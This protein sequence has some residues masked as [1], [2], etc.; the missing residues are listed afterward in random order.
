M[1]ID[2]YLGRQSSLV[3]QRSTN[4]KL[5]LAMSAVSDLDG[6]LQ[7]IADLKTS[8]QS[9]APPSLR[10]QVTRDAHNALAAGTGLPADV[11]DRYADAVTAEQAWFA[12][13]SELNELHR[14]L[15][16]IRDVRI[17]DGMDDMCSALN[18]EL[19]RILGELADLRE[20]PTSPEQAIVR[21][22]AAEWQRAAALREE[23][24]QVR[25]AHRLLLTYGLAKMAVNDF[26][27]LT[28]LWPVIA[29]A[30]ALGTIW[31]NLTEWWKNYGQTWQPDGTSAKFTPPWPDPDSSTFIDWLLEHPEADPWVPTFTQA[32]DLADQITSGARADQNSTREPDEQRIAAEAVRRRYGMDTAVASTL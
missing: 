1:R 31:P 27:D 15:V 11:M 12:G 24:R 13:Q 32:A 28:R 17:E 10:G 4:P 23:Y 26:A 2:T 16:E 29:H 25:D 9:V 6:I 20:V 7:T 5:A 19:L 18:D 30:S 21:G 3:G 14:Q 22:R 8:A